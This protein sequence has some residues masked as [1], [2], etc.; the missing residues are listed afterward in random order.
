MQIAYV[1][2]D[3]GIPIFGD[4]GASVHVRQMVRA[5][6]AEHEVDLFCMG[7]GDRSEEFPVRRLVVIPNPPSVSGDPTTERDLKRI[8]GVDLMWKGL[9][10]ASV[11]SSYDLVYERYSLFSDAGL[12]L[13]QA[14]RVPYLLEV[15]APLVQERQRVE[16]LPFASRALEIEREIFESADV[17]L[18]VSDA[19]ATYVSR[20]G[21][22]PDRIHVVPNGVDT[23]QFHPGVAGDAIRASLGEEVALVVGFVGSL[24]AWHG[25]DLLIQA[26][27]ETAGPDWRLLVVGHGPERSRLEEQAIQMAPERV[28]FTGPVPHE[29]IPPYLAAMDI[30]VAP[31]RSVPDFYFSSLKLFEYLA[32]GRAV[33]ASRV[34]QI[35]S[36]IAHCENGYLVPPDSGSALADALNRLGEDHAL[37]LRLACSAPEGLVTWK[38]TAQ[39]VVAIAER[40]K[41]LPR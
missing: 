10:R 39:R 16:P 2:A 27:G 26:F 11:H 25:V 38:Q 17:V 12:R 5:L 9:E 4:K 3:A 18:A 22:A 24:K 29:N 37:R 31:Y 13:A 6:A 23:A 15:N 28:I 30:A 33:I 34:G 40:A 36:I 21:A 1:L 32:A 41:P 35:A 19:V 8:A 20:Q 7:L 14:L